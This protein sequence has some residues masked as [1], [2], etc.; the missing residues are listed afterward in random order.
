VARG[1]SHRA[2]PTEV[3]PGSQAAS[4]RFRLLY[5]TRWC[6][7][8]NGSCG[9]RPV[10]VPPNSSYA[11]QDGTRIAPLESGGSGDLVAEA[12]GGLLSGRRG[13]QLHP[14]RPDDAALPIRFG[15]QW[16]GRQHG[17]PI[18]RPLPRTSVQSWSVLWRRQ[19]L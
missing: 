7:P 8:G 16:C 10:N 14:T 12:D 6:R 3:R 9:V 17:V 19:E 1:G 13:V 2:P 11:N 5:I 4:V 18:D 15:R